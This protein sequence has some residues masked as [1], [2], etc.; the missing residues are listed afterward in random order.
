[1]ELISLNKNNNFS[2]LKHV[3]YE[4]CTLK[5]EKDESIEDDE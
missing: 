2:S 4:K 1:M 3:K 5:E